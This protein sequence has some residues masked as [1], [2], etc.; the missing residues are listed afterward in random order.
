M[1]KIP[2]Y[3]GQMTNEMLVNL[4]L[5]SDFSHLHL[6]NSIVTYPVLSTILKIRYIHKHHT[7][8]LPVSE[9]NY[10]NS[11]TLLE[12]TNTNEEEE[13]SIPPPDSW[14]DIYNSS[15]EDK[16]QLYGKY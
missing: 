5:E 16:P 11:T 15:D 6:V 12:L 1:H 13:M 2:I 14:E 7:P 10:E 4:F 8:Y 3:N 9:N